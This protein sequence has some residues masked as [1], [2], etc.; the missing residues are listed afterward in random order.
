LKFNRIKSHIKYIIFY[1]S[2]EIRKGGK[3][4]G[5]KGGKNAGLE[6][7]LKFF[8]KIRIFR[9]SRI[10]ATFLKIG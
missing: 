3:R 5:K 4:A 1:F 9:E 6:E 2:K 8:K 10:F 7:I